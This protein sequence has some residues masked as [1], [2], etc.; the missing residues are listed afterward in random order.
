MRKNLL[1][2][3]SVVCSGLLLIVFNGCVVK[4]RSI[5]KFEKS[6]SISS[7]DFTDYMKKDFLITPGTYGNDYVALGMFTFA[8]YSEVNYIET[9]VEDEKGKKVIIGEW[10]TKELVK[11]DEVLA[12]AY[13][14]AIKKGSDAITHFTVSPTVKNEFDGVSNV[15]IPGLKM[16]GLLIKRK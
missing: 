12:Q 15:S 11:P 3:G 8:M 9:T 2:I 16:S 10:I 1:K 4:E 6:N 14:T 5:T 7:L 13:E